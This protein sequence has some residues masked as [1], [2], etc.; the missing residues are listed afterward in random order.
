VLLH[1]EVE[2]ELAGGFDVAL[3]V[4]PAAAGEADDRGASQK[5]LKKLYGARLTRPPGSTLEI[6][7]IGRGATMALNG[8][9]GSPCPFRGS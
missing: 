5:A 4:L 7:P 3:A 1:G 9:W 6:Q 8:S 2:D